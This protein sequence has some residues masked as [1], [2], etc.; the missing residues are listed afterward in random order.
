[1]PTNSKASKG[2]IT[3][4][5]NQADKRYGRLHNIRRLV[6]K[7]RQRRKKNIGLKKWREQKGQLQQKD[8]EQQK[9]PKP[10][11]EE[12]FSIVSSESSSE[13]LG[14]LIYSGVHTSEISFAKSANGRNA[15][16]GAGNRA[17]ANINGRQ[18]K[19]NKQSKAMQSGTGSL[20]YKDA[21]AGKS[22]AGS[23]VDARAGIYGSNAGKPTAKM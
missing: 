5:K 15:S 13:E 6:A 4:E 22:S 14:K 17:H 11:L 2:L 12:L 8:N 7:L 19:K 20:K 21:R 10:S 18:C 23:R 9:K 16:G 1:M 3:P